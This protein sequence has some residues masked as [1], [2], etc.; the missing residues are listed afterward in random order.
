MSVEDNDPEISIAP[1]VQ[2]TQSNQHVSNP[3]GHEDSLDMYRVDTD[4]STPVRNNPSKVPHITHWSG[5]K[6]DGREVKLGQLIFMSGKKLLERKIENAAMGL[7]EQQYSHAEHLEEMNEMF[8][9][10]LKYPPGTL[11]KRIKAY[12]T[13]ARASVAEENKTGQGLFDNSVFNQE[14]SQEMILVSLLNDANKSCVPPP[15]NTRPFYGAAS[16]FEANGPST[17]ED[18]SQSINLEEGGRCVLCNMESEYLIGTVIGLLCNP[19]MQAQSGNSMIAMKEQ[20][21]N[22]AARANIEQQNALMKMDQVGHSA[23]AKKRK[24]PKHRN[25]SDGG[26]DDDAGITALLIARMKRDDVK[27]ELEEKRFQKNQEK[28]E[29]KETRQRKKEELEMKKLELEVK[30]AQKKLDD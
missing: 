13:A 26:S 6:I 25:D 27:E 19:C 24:A 20:E 22:L 12:I 18:A 2:R 3:N 11:Q 17:S 8:N 9:E 7:A 21:D 29:E 28:V 4:D 1:N 5:V 16:R 15:K 23:K 14:T 30:L 10:T